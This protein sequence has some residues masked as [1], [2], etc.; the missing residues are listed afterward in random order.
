MKGKSRGMWV[1]VL[2]GA[3]MFLVFFVPE[4]Q[5]GP[6]E[7]YHVF[8]GKA[9]RSVSDNDTLYAAPGTVVYARTVDD[10]QTPDL[11][12]TGVV[13]EEGRYEIHIPMENAQ[14]MYYVGYVPSRTQGNGPCRPI[15]YCHIDIYPYPPVAH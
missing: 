15:P 11:I 14:Y 10:G 8:Y 2:A 12:Y 6:K 13:E 7:R 3:L 5:A 4:M 1:V 9:I